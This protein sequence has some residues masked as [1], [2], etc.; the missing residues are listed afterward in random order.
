MNLDSLRQKIE[1]AVED[2]PERGV[3]RVRRE[4][5]ADPELFEIEL[6]YIFEGN[7]VYVA[8]ESQIPNPNDFFTTYIGRQPVIVSRDKSGQLGM[9]LNACAHR[10]AKL[11]R[12]KKGN[13]P[14]HTCTFHGW[15]FRADGK[16]IKV[17]DPEG[18]GYPSSFDNNPAYDLQRVARFESYRG[19][20]FAS[21]SPDVLPLRE[22]L[23][24]T[25]T[26]IDMIVEQSPDGL[27][28]LRG[29]STY[30]YDGNWKLQAENGT[31][32]YHVT[33][34]HWNY[35][36]TITRRMAGM[37]GDA[38]QAMDVSR[39]T[40]QKGGFYAFPHGHICLWLRWPN[41][42]NRPLYEQRAELLER[43]GETRTDWMISHARNLCLY[44]NVLLMDQMSSQ[45]R[46]FRPISVD[47]TEVT[48][49]CIAPKGESA[50]ARTHRIRQYE[51]FF[52]AAGMATPDDL[53]EFR[54]CQGGYQAGA[55]EWNDI[56]RGARHWI[57]G[58]DEDAERL[59]L[60]PQMSGARQEDEGL[61]LVHHKDWQ[62][63]LK[64][65]LDREQAGG[66]S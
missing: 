51:D 53:E 18:A 63:R 17:K 39:W 12:I 4:M 27:E 42:Q 38:V 66:A 13:K 22:Y 20:L 28:V 47:K 26:L 7:W 23:G 59:G 21:L 30:V 61:Y 5:F 15:S 32:G 10:G 41:P 48:I 16:L 64:R 9:F 11:C 62:Q 57:D 56:S 65:A 35:V 19:F 33:S 60:H 50:E 31:D 34:V 44:P 29:A 36:A 2:D 8:H 37:S 49:Y 55:A 24:D 45:I 40:S 52:N 43:C 25:T 58:P 54:A 1:R 46:V 3:F 14:V 6:K